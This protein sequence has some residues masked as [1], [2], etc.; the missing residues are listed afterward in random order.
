MSPSL[1]HG[2]FKSPHWGSCLPGRIAPDRG[3]RPYGRG[4]H[5][6]STTLLAQAVEH[7]RLKAAD[8]STTRHLRFDVGADEGR[9]R[10]GAEQATRIGGVGSSPGPRV[11]R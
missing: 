6:R 3:D 7:S 10:G 11:T 5:R 2:E 8:R 4:A 9:A 1:Y